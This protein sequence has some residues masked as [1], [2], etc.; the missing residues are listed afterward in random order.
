MV[1]A[2]MG[3]IR[4]LGDNDSADG[5]NRNRRVA[6]VILGAPPEATDARPGG[7]AAEPASAAPV[8]KAA[9][10]EEITG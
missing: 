4:P 9:V 10:T 2:G 3:E 1:V 6:V 8:L 7:M 5:R